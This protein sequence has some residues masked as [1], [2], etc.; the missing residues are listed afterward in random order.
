M[1]IPADRF[2]RLTALRPAGP[3]RGRPDNRPEPNSLLDQLPGCELRTNALGRHLARVQR[4]SQPHP[5]EIPG[6]TL[7]LLLP[8]AR[9]EAADPEGWILLD[10]ETTGL[11]GGTGTYAFLAGLAWWEADE[12]VV[13]Q[14]FMRDFGEEAS[15][16]AA[17]AERLAGRHVL[18]TY[19][20]KS[21]D[22]PLL[23]TRYRMTRAA[24]PAAPRSHMDLIHPARQIWR[25]SL[26]SVALSELERQVL[27][28]GRPWDIPSS[29]IPSLYFDY[30]RGGPARPLADVFE[31]NQMDLRGLA[32]LA[33][34]IVQMLDDPFAAGCGGAELYGISRMLQRSGD[35]PSAG[36]ACERALMQGLPAEVERAARKDLAYMARR[37]RD[38]EC[39]NLHWEQLV[40][41]PLDG[42]LACEQLA[43]HHE[44]RTHDLERA[45][46]LVRRAL[47]EIRD[48]FQSR[49]IP[50]Q[51]YYSQHTRLSHRLERL[52]RKLQ[53]H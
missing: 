34:K 45:A 30:L 11:A 46:S 27:G 1:T 31:H 7:H 8:G 29:L 49:R 3:G 17:L 16:L 50:P 22:W 25:H 51:T 9:T 20:G 48:G 40:E 26:K 33:V 5:R 4:F 10:T 37:R 28:R 32:A 13:E 6:R 21:F 43:I 38:F 12:L 44:Y 39:A 35:L 52:T 2:S 41:D 24:A 23:E 53:Q 15:L 36:S 14:Y 47:A 19:N 42:L 18:V